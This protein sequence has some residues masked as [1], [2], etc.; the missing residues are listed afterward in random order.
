M[1]HF[2]TT[3]LVPEKNTDA[4]AKRLRSD[5]LVLRYSASWT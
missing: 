1:D 2:N 5:I 4:V 3:I